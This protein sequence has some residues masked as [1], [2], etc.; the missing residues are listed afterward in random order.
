M[1]SQTE[2]KYFVEVANCL[3]LSRASERLGLSQPSL[4]VAIQRLENSIGTALLIRHTK[5]VTLTQA[6][7][8]LLAHAKQLLQYW[9][10]IKSQALASHH[11]IQGSFTIGCHPSIGLAYLA[12][13]L[14]DLLSKYPKLEIQLEHDL[15]RKISERVISLS[16]D[17]G[18]IVNPIKHP[19]L[20]IH[21][22]KNDE[23]TFWRSNKHKN[24]NLH[25]ENSV[26]ICDPALTQTQWLL[27]K[28]QT[29]RGTHHRIIQTSNLE[30]IANLTAN[31]CGIG[32]LPA[33]VGISLYPKMLTPIPQAP[34]FKDEICLAYRHEN[35]D[36]KAIQTIVNAI[37]SCFTK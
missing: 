18:L 34:I 7:K 36:I 15:S 4:S 9:D 5:G 17:I 10:E 27:K 33:S 26:I 22:L 20:I 37:K 19:D 14:P 25:S 30:I 11:D 32:I 31:G 6:G 35:R 12:N 28:A 3:N 1:S 23:V 21:K 29:N 16:V 2:L 13:F 8:Q 24:L